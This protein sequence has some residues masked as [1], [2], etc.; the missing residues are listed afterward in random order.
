M[1]E[2]KPIEAK[3]ISQS[4]DMINRW[5]PDQNQYDYLVKLL[6]GIYSMGFYSGSAKQS[7]VLTEFIETID[8]R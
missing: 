2:L 7:K 8:S 1:L 5:H 6:T 4:A 3:L